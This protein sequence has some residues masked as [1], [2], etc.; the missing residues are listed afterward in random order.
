VNDATGKNGDKTAGAFDV[1]VIVGSL[2]G[3]YAVILLLMAAFGDQAGEKTGDVNANLW[4]GL[5]LAVI[6]AVFLGWA[7]L[8]PIVVVPPP[9]EDE[10]APERPAH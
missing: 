10:K 3:I 7:K 2:M 9:E 4:A 6:S 1:R 8:R 5:A